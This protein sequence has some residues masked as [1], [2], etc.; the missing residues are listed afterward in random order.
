M[1]LTSYAICDTGLIRDENQDNLFINGAIRESAED[2]SVFRH[3]DVS[4]GRGI[5]A[6]ADGMGGGSH[7]G[8][9]SLVTVREMQDK[10][11]YKDHNS[12]SQFLLQC[13]ENICELMNENKS[14]RMGSTFVGLCIDGENG[15][16]TN[17][18][19]SRIYL[20]RCDELSQLSIDHTSIRQMVELGVITEDAARTHPDRHR[21][22]QHLGIFSSEML[23]EPHTK[24]IDLQVRDIFL[25]CSDGLT[26]MLT[27]GDIQRILSTNSTKEEKAETLFAEALKNGGRDNITIVIVAV[28]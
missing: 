17:I 12:M 2:T 10:D 5:Y 23:I 9:A 24:Q 8:L 14:G 18:G 1:T 22:T 28:F 6:V 11:F 20:F 19:D 7:G 4:E 27:D 3:F 25:L 15:V 26:D 21:L 16:V 13:N